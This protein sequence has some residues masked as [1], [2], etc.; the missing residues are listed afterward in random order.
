MTIYCLQSQDGGGS[1]DNRWV[2]NPEGP[3]LPGYWTSVSAD[4]WLW[5]RST[6]ETGRPVPFRNTEPGPPTSCLA[7]LSS[8]YIWEAQRVSA[9]VKH[10]PISHR[11]E[12]LIYSNLKLISKP[13]LGFPG[14][15]A[16]WLR[17]RLPMQGTRVQ[18]LVQE[19]PTCRGAT[20]PVRHNYWACALEPASH[21]Y[22]ACVPQLLKPACLETVPRNKRS[23]RNEK[24]AH[25]NEE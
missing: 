18:A 1:Q 20:K 8:L 6:M 7:F 24:P 14:V 21:N 13:P 4:K 11:T 17:I 12:S 2:G 16:Q 9:E 19:D 23:H 5:T 15:V 22:W 25:C 3:A 10:D